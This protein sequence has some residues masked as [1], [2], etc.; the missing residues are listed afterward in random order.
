MWWSWMRAPGYDQMFVCKRIVL[1]WDWSSPVRPEYR[2]Q[3]ANAAR[4]HHQMDIN[5]GCC[6]V[7]P[8]GGYLFGCVRQFSD[9]WREHWVLHKRTI[10]VRIFVWPAAIRQRY[11]ILDVRF[12]NS[13][14]PS[15]QQFDGAI[16][17]SIVDAVGSVVSPS[18]TTHDNRLRSPEIGISLPFVLWFLCSA[19]GTID[20]LSAGKRWHLCNCIFRQHNDWCVRS[21]W[22]P[23]VKDICGAVSARFGGNGKCVGAVPANGERVDFFFVH[24]S[25]AGLQWL[26]LLCVPVS[27]T[28]SNVFAWLPIQTEFNVATNAGWQVVVRRRLLF[29]R[30]RGNY[31]FD[32]G[33]SGNS[34]DPME[35]SVELCFRWSAT[36]AMLTINQISPRK[37][38][39]Y[40]MNVPLK[41]GTKSDT[42]ERSV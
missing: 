30:V 24:Y 7:H 39:R 5:R 3:N 4:L 33:F 42:Y 35:F 15:Y 9:H 37:W 26:S 16:L 14:R 12:V 17:P 18:E 8:C 13:G 28:G 29:W 32:Q 31:G 19:L 34:T 6:M 41:S 21:T 36:V 20:N 10:C 27:L 38:S 22:K 2:R 25:S 23:Y 40:P 11:P 1:G